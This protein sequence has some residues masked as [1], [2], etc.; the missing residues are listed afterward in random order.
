MTALQAKNTPELK[1]EIT[2]RHKELLRLES[3]QKITALRFM[4]KI[5]F[6]ITGDNGKREVIYLNPV[7]AYLANGVETL[8][9][10]EGRKYDREH[11]LVEIYG[12][13]FPH[14]KIVLF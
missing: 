9:F 10:K 7:F 14:L 8:E 6:G 1:P 3:L 2:A 13:I 5:A 11:R 4:P 12:K